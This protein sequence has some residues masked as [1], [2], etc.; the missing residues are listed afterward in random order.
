MSKFENLSLAVADGIATITV[1]RPEA[2]NA[3]NLPTLLELES[4]L[5]QAA[6]DDGVR[7]IVVTG[8]GDRAFI[9]GADIGDM[10]TRRGLAFYL[11]FTEV[12]HRVFRRFETCDKPTIAAVNGWALGGGVE[13]ILSLDIRILADNARLGL[14]EITL[15]LF[16]GA[17]G[18]QRLIRQISPCRAREMMFAGEPIDA[19]EAVSLGLANRVVPKDRLMEEVRELA[20]KIARKS[21]LTLKLM[22]RTLVA[23][24]DMPLDAALAHERAMVSLLMDSE[25]AHE[26]CDAFLEKRAPDFKGR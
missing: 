9:A 16:P 10:N 19:Q 12:N 1:D 8:A 5:D 25:D 13:L 11:E 21:S 3:L 23:G 4:A 26:G 18:T 24:C 22:K 6:D 15:G 14:P 2:R 20:L 7:V 17:G